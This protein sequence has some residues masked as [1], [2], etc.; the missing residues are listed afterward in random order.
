MD[1]KAWHFAL[2]EQAEQQSAA[3]VAWART[4]VPL[5]MIASAVSSH[6]GDPADAASGDPA[7]A[8][9]QQRAMI[10]SSRV[11][12]ALMNEFGNTGYTYPG[13]AVLH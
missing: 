10:G 4:S 8:A 12:L 2:P 3:D 5:P 7:G 6:G 11:F 1:V 13:T 9:S